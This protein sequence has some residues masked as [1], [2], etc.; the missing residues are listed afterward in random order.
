MYTAH[1]GS[2]CRYELYS[3]VF[4]LIRAALISAKLSVSYR[5][6]SLIDLHGQSFLS[7]RIL[8]ATPDPFQASAYGAHDAR[9]T[10]GRR[11]CITL[12]YFCR[13]ILSKILVL[14]D[15][16]LHHEKAAG[17]P[18]QDVQG[19]AQTVG[20]GTTTAFGVCRIGIVALFAGHG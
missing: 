6:Q 3:A 9:P 17:P 11:S 15:V 20:T 2:S 12:R 4:A 1:W 19:E 7:Q 16:I 18:R 5:R 10:P 8:G 14:R 13:Q